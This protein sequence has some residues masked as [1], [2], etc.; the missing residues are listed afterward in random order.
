ML[1][2]AL[3]S[4]ER[5]QIVLSAAEGKSDLEIAAA[6][7]ISNQK[8]A[9]WRK[10]FLRLGLPGLQKDA[11]RPGRKPVIPARIK[12]ELVRKTTQSKPANATH[13]STR[14]MATE[15]GVSEA[16]VRRIWH[17]NG[18]KPH[19]LKTF[20]VSKDKHFAEKL[21]AIVGLYLNPP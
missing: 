8:A 21:E 18:L 13:W 14:T 4:G 2:A 11:P 6:L 17:A 9:R 5:A 3:P 20:K 16:T 1:S 15:M 10:R 19:R 12:E 7:R